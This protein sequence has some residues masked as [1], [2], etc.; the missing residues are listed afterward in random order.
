RGDDPAAAHEE[1]GALARDDR[2]ARRLP[3]GG[4]E[5]AR[6]LVRR[7]ALRGREE[8]ALQR[9]AP[10]RVGRRD[11]LLDPRRR[12]LRDALR[13]LDEVR[14]AREELARARLRGRERARVAGAPAVVE[15]PGTERVA[16]DR[17]A[18]RVER[19]V[20]VAGD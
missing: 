18:P 10:R 4:V 1:A 14:E 3:D 19:R 12:R 20:G 5:R 9:I 7:R 16:L 2:A 13:A 15:E 6:R 8:G 11:D 17:V